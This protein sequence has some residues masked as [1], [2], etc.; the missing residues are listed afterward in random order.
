[1]KFPVSDFGNIDPIGGT[2]NG[3]RN[4]FVWKGQQKKCL[5]TKF[6]GIFKTGLTNVRQYGKN[7]EG[8]TQQKAK[9]Y[10]EGNK[11]IIFNSNVYLVHG[12]LNELKFNH[13]P[14][15]LEKNLKL[16]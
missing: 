8:R 2:C 16:I 11:L 9:I 4:T 1:M 14:P 10:A 3:R 5:N 12:K 6:S 15:I 7:I 13:T